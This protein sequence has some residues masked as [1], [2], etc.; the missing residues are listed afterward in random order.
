M[1]TASWV[2][3][4][5]VGTLTLVGSLFSV[6]IAY[7]SVVEDKIGPASLTELSAGR[8]EVATAVPARRATAAAYGA[9]FATLAR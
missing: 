6:G 3:L 9:G 2:I 7:F 8:P 4:A 1:K 5:V